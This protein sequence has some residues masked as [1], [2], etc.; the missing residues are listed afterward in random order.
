[1]RLKV[2]SIKDVAET[3]LCCGCGVCAYIS[4]DEIR[5]VDDE[6]FGRRPLT[7]EQSSDVRTSDAIRSCPG[8][9]LEH[10]F[11]RSAPGMKRELVPAWGPVLGV[12]EG[13]AGDGAIRRAGSSGG[14]AT[15][16]AL[17]A[18][19]RGGMYGVLHTAAQGDRPYLNETVMSTTR[20]DLLERTGSRYAPASPCEGLGLIEAAPG[21]C[22]FIG[23]PCDVAAAQMARRLMPQLDARLGLTIA[24]FCAGTPSTRGTLELL[25]SVG[26]DDPYSITS[27]RYRGNGWPGRWTVRWIAADGTEHEASRSYEESWGFLQQYRPWR[28]SICPDHTG[29]F[30]DVSVGDPWYRPVE[31]AEPGKS[32]IVARSQRG[33]DAVKAAAHDGYLILEREDASLLPRSQPNLLSVRGRLWGQMLALRAARVPRPVYRGFETFSFWARLPMKKKIQSTLGTLRRVV[34]RGLRERSPVRESGCAPVG[35]ER[36]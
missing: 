21:P 31:A 9:G 22:V 33:M 14:A 20:S 18:V 16:L 32:L 34:S 29:E 2:L 27:L 10:T 35:A 28:C 7:A 26:I 25:K 3:Q 17:H 15:A 8:I 12:W 36:L 19:E 5:M 30:G 13:F 6:R 11:D 23:K 4:P 24:F 1:M